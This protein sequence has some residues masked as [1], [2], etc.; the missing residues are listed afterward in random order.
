MTNQIFRRLASTSQMMSIFDDEAVLQAMLDFERALAVS[1]AQ[2]GLFESSVADSIGE[3][4]KVSRFSIPDLS[5]AATQ[6]GTIVVPLV[7]QLTKLV[8]THDNQASGWVH[9]GATSQDVIDTA[10]VIQLKKA[11]RI[12]SGDFRRLV[13]SLDNLFDNYCNQIMIGRTLLQPSVP[14]TFGQKVFGWKSA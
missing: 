11:I 6:H 1:E 12:L 14:I 2:C 9:F 8:S 4:C 5:E 3:C 7:E 10:M 13:L